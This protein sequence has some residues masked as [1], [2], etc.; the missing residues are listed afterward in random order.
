MIGAAG[1]LEITSDG[2]VK[3]AP[4]ILVS[5]LLTAGADAATIILYDNASTASG[6]VLATVKAAANL[7]A[8][9][10]PTSGYAAANGI[11][12]DVTGTSPTAYVVYV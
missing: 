1:H 2:V 11:Y 8:Q 9:W 7:T 10:T 5:V 6:T 4:G 3:A 12:A